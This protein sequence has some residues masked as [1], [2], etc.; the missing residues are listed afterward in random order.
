LI[1]LLVVIGILAI[2]TTITVLVLNPAQL[3]AQARDSQRISDMGT[4]KSAI[5]LYLTSSGGSDLDG[6]SGTFTC[7]TNYGA[8][9]APV[10]AGSPGAPFS[11]TIAV[12]HTGNFDISGAGWVPVNLAS[13]T[14]GSPIPVLPRDP[15]NGTQSGVDYFYAYACDNSLKT[16]ELNANMES[17]RYSA[18]GDDDVESTDGGNRN[19]ID[20]TALYEVGTD[21]GLNL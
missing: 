5:S 21:A 1:E 12:P 10:T 8:S 7:G 4:L 14:G 9:F 13:T 19:A 17:Q 18:G 2:L 11:A 15:V 6:A 3:F 20:A 16:F